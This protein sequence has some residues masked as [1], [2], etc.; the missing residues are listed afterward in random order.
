MS[1]LFVN[2]IDTASGTTITIP[3]GKKLVGTDA[4]GI[5]SPGM[6]IQVINSTTSVA[7]STTSATYA[8][9]GLAAT[10]TPKYS[11]SKILVQVNIP[12]AHNGGTTS[13]LYLNLVRGSTQIIEFVR[14]G[15]HISPATSIVT[16]GGSTSYLDAPST[17]SATTYKVQFRV[18]SSGGSQHIFLNNSVGTITLMEIA[19]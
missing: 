3:T 16:Y 18:H 4:G 11:N 8:D 13:L 12:D 15:D 6:V 19:Q 14:H 9:T 5:T 2:N 1:T 10:I 7:V 17:T